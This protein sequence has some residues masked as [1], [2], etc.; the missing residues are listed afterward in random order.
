[1][2]VEDTRKLLTKWK[3]KEFDGRYFEMFAVVR[4]DEIVGSISLYQHSKNVVSCGPETFA[5]YQ[6]QGVAQTAMRLAMEYAKKKGYGLVL[7]QI[8]VDNYASIELHKKI[9]FETDGYVY[10]NR[11]GNDVLIFI[12]LLQDK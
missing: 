7:Q 5:C 12:K 10:K 9:G 4:D 1:M 3:E 11:K 6:R 2:T 8:R